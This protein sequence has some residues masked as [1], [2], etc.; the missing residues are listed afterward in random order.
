MVVVSINI[1][2]DG[3]PLEKVLEKQGVTFPVIRD[4]LSMTRERYRV[5]VT[6][7]AFFIDSDGVLRRMFV[8]R[9]QPS[10][11]AALFDEAATGML[12]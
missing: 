1:D 4:S 2:P 3:T 12:R 5:I 9:Q 8:G 10:K 11:L 7:T 6:P